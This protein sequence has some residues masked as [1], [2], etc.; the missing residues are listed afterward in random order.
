MVP[1]R[2]WI[3]K[4]KFRE[5]VGAKPLVH[6][7]LENGCKNFQAITIPPH[8]LGNCIMREC[9]EHEVCEG[10]MHHDRELEIEECH[11]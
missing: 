9:A 11:V 1:I 4:G 7:Y 2:V 10:S 8:L 5:E 6:H 3:P